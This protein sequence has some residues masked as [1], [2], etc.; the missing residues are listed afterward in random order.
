M[1]LTYETL[2]PKA[3][4]SGD[5]TFWV[6][7]LTC[8]E[9][10]GSGTVSINVGAELALL[11]RRMNRLLDRIEPLLDDTETSNGDNP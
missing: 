9:C 3:R 10:H 8:S 5:E 1:K 2:C 7:E 11:V 6:C 4:L